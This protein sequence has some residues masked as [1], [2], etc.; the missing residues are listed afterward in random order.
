MNIDRKIDPVELA[1]ENTPARA[2]V[3]EGEN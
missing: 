3:R 1:T 2:G